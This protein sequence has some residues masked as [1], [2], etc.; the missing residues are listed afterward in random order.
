VL[1]LEHL[2]ADGGGAARAAI[3]KYPAQQMRPAHC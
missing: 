3:A 2:S 1:R